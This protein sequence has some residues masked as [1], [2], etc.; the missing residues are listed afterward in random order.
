MRDTYF[1]VFI[2]KE[3]GCC[4][5]TLKIDDD[6]SVSTK[7]DDY[8]F[9]PVTIITNDYLGK[10]YFNNLWYSRIYNEY[11]KDNNPIETSGYTDIEWVPIEAKKGPIVHKI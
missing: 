4:M 9:M 10:Y 6:T 3:T 11:D 5:E 8:Y 7:N 1:Y 2:D